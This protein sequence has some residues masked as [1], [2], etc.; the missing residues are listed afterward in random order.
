MFTAILFICF[1]QEGAV[2]EAGFGPDDRMLA[3]ATRYVG[4]QVMNQQNNKLFPKWFII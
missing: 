1:I 2:V 3:Y 4:V